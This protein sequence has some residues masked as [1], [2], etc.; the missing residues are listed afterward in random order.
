MNKGLQDRFNERLVRLTGYE[1]R[2]PSFDQPVVKP[3][4]AKE[5]VKVR[6]TPVP[7]LQRQIAAAHDPE[8]Q[9]R[10]AAI[11]GPTLSPAIV[12]SAPRAGGPQLRAALNVH[13]DIYA[14]AEL[15]LMNLRVQAPQAAQQALGRQGLRRE[16]LD[17]MLWDHL[18]RE[19]LAR[20]GARVAV[21]GTSGG[22]NVAEQWRRLKDV[23][24]AARFVHLIRDPAKVLAEAT[25]GQGG[26]VEDAVERL[27][28]LIAALAHAR[29]SLPGLTVRHEELVESP[30]Q[31]LGPVFEFLG[32]EPDPAVA[33]AFEAPES[34]T[35]PEPAAPL[36]GRLLG[37][38]RNWGYV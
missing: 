23:W 16:D 30:A 5:P 15:P 26:D 6:A 24:P 11:I 37:V 35:Q 7:E 36:T 14:P 38:A 18:L 17:N 29:Q 10:L 8:A 33:A 25:A 34:S 28:K 12:F 1:L 31:A 32:V 21:I 2:R 3:P 27:G 20:S 4:T 13:P 9:A 19:R 22:R